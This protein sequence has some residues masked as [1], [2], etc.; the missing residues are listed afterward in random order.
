MDGDKNTLDSATDK[1]SGRVHWIQYQ[2]GVNN[3]VCCPDGVK[4]GH[5]LHG[6]V[7]AITELHAVVVEKRTTRE[8]AHS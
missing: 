4:E 1:M 3:I 2:A 5:T 7:T 6:V 8:A